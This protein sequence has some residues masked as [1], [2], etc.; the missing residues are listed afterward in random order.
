MT[1][2]SCLGDFDVVLTFLVNRVGLVRSD[3]SVVCTKRSG[4]LLSVHLA[5]TLLAHFASKVQSLQAKCALKIGVCRPSAHL[6]AHQ[7][8]FALAPF[9]SAQVGRKTQHLHPT[10]ALCFLRWNHA[11]LCCRT[12]YCQL[13]LDSDLTIFVLPIN[14][15]PASKSVYI[16]STPRGNRQGINCTR[17]CSIAERFICTLCLRLTVLNPQISIGRCAR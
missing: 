8:N 16:L 12:F 17:D 14:N 3:A 5:C 9:P 10:C 2:S 6:K 13:L 7:T 4:A 1:K 15:T 11:R